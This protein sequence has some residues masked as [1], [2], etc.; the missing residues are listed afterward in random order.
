VLHQNH[1]EPKVAIHTNLTFTQNRFFS[2]GENKRKKLRI[3]TSL[4]VRQ[5]EASFIS[6][7]LSPCN[8]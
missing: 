2:K 7:P 5:M 1:S 3:E 4:L 8:T 6:Y